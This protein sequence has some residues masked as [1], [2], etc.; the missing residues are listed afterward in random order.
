[1]KGAFKLDSKYYEQFYKNSPTA[2]S[3]Q[4]VIY[5]NDGVP[6]DLVFSDY[7]K[8][9]ENLM[10]L[11]GAETLNKRFI[12]VFPNCLENINDWN[13][14]ILDAVIN[15]KSIQ[16]D[17][18]P[19][20][21]QKWIRMMIFPL[22]RDTLGCIYSDV[23]K[24]YIQDNEI[25]GFLNVNI[26]M[27]S[28]VNSNGYFLRVNQAF[29]RILGYKVEEL[30]GSSFTKLVHEDDLSS[31]LNRIKDLQ[32][33]KHISTFINRVRRKD[34][35]Y[36]YL[37]WHSQLNGKYIY[38]SARDI[39]ERRT[40]EEQLFEKNKNLAQLTEELKEKNKILKTLALTDELTG[41]YNRHF[42]DQKIVDEMNQSDIDRQSLSMI[43]IDID[44][45]KQVNDTW[46]HPVGDEVLKQTAQ[47]LKK[48]LRHSDTLIRLGGEE[49]MIILPDT[50][51][52]KAINIAERV[53]KSIEQFKYPIAGQLTASLG[54][55]QRE[56]LESFNDWYIRADNALYKA[57]E[58]ERNCVVKV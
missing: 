23:T 4:K 26:D 46:G 44:F 58:M 47:I 6:M 53:R 42:L 17:I 51:L 40:L 16:F 34:G 25:E 12:D 31:T 10:E 24:E 21:S 45:F 19:F 52:D 56:M 50:N 41:L 48:M 37:E 13:K 54:V 2:Y 3:C 8:A 9:F 33:Q 15:K 57:K 7:N 43:I 30:E 35:V 11:Q 36:R 18:I 28:V 32:N 22:Q 1:M 14:Y 38:S 49:F 20:S 29:E 5:D 55:A 39:T 27:L